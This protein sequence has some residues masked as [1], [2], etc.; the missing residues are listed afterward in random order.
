MMGR[1]SFPKQLN[2]NYA[3]FIEFAEFTVCGVYFVARLRFLDSKF[4]LWCNTSLFS[5]YRNGIS[6][7]NQETLI[8]FMPNV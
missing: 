4:V 8:K 7:D 6:V 2:R 3:D 1:Q 5:F